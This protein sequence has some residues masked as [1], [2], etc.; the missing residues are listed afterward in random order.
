MDKRHVAVELTPVLIVVQHT[1]PE[2]SLLVGPTISGA[3]EEMRGVGDEVKVATTCSEWIDNPVGATRTLQTW[4]MNR[5]EVAL[6]CSTIERCCQHCQAHCLDTM[7]C[8]PEQLKK[9]VA[10]QSAAW[11]LSVRELEPGNQPSHHDTTMVF[12]KGSVC[13]SS[14][15]SEHSNCREIDTR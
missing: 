7:N 14:S 4:S 6:G 11:K 3:L 9:I 13:S 15:A 1:Y 2:T 10:R 5:D 8:F 12:A